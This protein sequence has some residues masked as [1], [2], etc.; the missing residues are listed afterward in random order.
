MK[1]I[2]LTAIPSRFAGFTPTQ[3]SLLAQGANMVRLHIP[4]SYRRFPDWD[5]NLLKVPAGV[6]IVRCNTDLGPATKVLPA[7]QDLRGQDAQILF[8]DDDCIVPPGEPTVW[9][10]CI[11]VFGGIWFAGGCGGVS[12]LGRLNLGAA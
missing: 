8:C 11:A 1:I 9:P 4:R 10:T 7:T 2:S 3:E 6:S 5:G 12:R